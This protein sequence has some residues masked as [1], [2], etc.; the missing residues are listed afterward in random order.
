MAA[1]CENC[2]QHTG[3]T[4]HIEV[5]GLTYCHELPRLSAGASITVHVAQPGKLP[6][7]DVELGILDRLA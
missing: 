5:Q 2:H 7:L 3:N 6:I 1:D 4:L